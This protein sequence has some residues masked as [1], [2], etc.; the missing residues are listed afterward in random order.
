MLGS[1]DDFMFHL[2]GV[3]T[4]W[5]YN[6]EWTVLIWKLSSSLSFLGQSVC[7]DFKVASKITTK[8]KLPIECLEDEQIGIVH[9]KCISHMHNYYLL[10]I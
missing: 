1:K 9:C 2:V 4:S 7:V 8:N 3:T 5:I 6:N 10:W